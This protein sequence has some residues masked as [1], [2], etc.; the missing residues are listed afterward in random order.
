ML[1]GRRFIRVLVFWVKDWRED[2]YA[3]IDVMFKVPHAF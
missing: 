2:I 3:A 1:K